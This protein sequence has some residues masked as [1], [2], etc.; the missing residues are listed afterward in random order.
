MLMKKTC[1]VPQRG[2]AATLM[3]RNRQ[4]ARVGMLDLELESC[5]HTHLFPP[6][7]H[8]LHEHCLV[9]K[10]AAY[11]FRRQAE[12][13]R[14]GDSRAARLASETSRGFAALRSHNLGLGS[15]AP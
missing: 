9:S 2:Q 4:P 1:V 10:R 14:T 12:R 8:F 11:V 7:E 3:S 13:S 15:C 6:H 5:N